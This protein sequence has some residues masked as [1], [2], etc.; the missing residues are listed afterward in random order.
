MKTPDK[1]AAAKAAPAEAR[2]HDG[3]RAALKTGLR[4]PAI[5]GGIGSVA[6]LALLLLWADY[7]R[8]NGAVIASGQAVVRGNPK[9]VQSLDGG[10]VAD[11]RVED[12]DFVEKGDLLLKLDPTL[13]EIN[14][15]IYRNRLAE[16][17][18]LRDRLKAEHHGL[19]RIERSAPPAQLAGLDL[20]EQYAGQNEI[21]EAR[22][23]LH[24]GKK[25]Q[26]QERIAQFRNQIDGVEGQIE[27]KTRQLDYIRQELESK[28]SLNAKG[29]MREA[30]VLAL[31][32]SEAAL[33]GESVGHRSELARIENSIRDTQMEMLQSDRQMMEEVVTD[34]RDATT[35]YE[36][37]LLELVTLEKQLDRIDIVAPVDGVVHESQVYTV[38]GVVPPESVIMQIV[39]VSEGVEYEVRIDP[40]AIDQVYV[41][42]TA[43]VQ[44][45]A[46]DMK[47]APILYGELVKISPNTIR[48]ETTGRSYYRATVVLPEEELRGLGPVHLVPG[49]PV[50]AFMQT[51]ERSVLDYLTKPLSDQLKRAFREG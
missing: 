11:I 17:V 34:L 33:L 37:L 24:Q 3:A 51:G 12:G 19:D 4:W 13:L 50:E 47:T 31:Q 35:R 48:D 36:E 40:T 15:D 2:R 26:L 38:G 9:V 14:R 8:I 20:E 23:A 25:E 27:A 30:D 1:T 44:F 32:R 6:L 10:V 5:L 16:T 41:G 21:F 22:R 45:P 42:Q 46:F 7:T 43:K 29:L 49:M 28:Q 18:A 39:P